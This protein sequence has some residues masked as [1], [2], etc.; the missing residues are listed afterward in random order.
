IRRVRTISVFAATLGLCAGAACH[1]PE[2]EETSP[3]TD[4]LGTAVRDYT[5]FEADPVRPVA[6]LET[7]GW[8]AVANTPD[9]VL[10]IFQPSRNTVRSCA[11]LK[12]GM[13]PVAVAV[14]REER[15]RATLWVVNHLSDS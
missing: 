9:D 5:L 7:S 12:V 8:V 13:R 3:A 2:G 6:V 15:A 10:E 14:V 11:R 1:S 4:E